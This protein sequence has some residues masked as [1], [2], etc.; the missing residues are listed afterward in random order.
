MES[1]VAKVQHLVEMLGTTRENAQRLLA[2]C[3]WIVDESVQE[4]FNE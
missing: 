1:C 3:N 4:H 2:K